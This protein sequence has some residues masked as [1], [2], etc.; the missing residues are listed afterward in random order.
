MFLTQP[1]LGTEVNEHYYLNFLAHVFHGVADELC[2]LFPAEEKRGYQDLAARWREHLDGPGVRETMYHS[3]VWTA[4]TKW[5]KPE[6]KET[7]VS[8]RS[9]HRP[10]SR[11]SP[12]PPYCR[13][14]PVKLGKH[15][16]VS[17]MLSISGQRNQTIPRLSFTLMT[18]TLSA[19]KQRPAKRS[20]TTCLGL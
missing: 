3:I 11:R 10:T 12:S 9:G 8:L 18:L 6:V 19:W 5:V 13:L 15:L 1:T 17:P 20:T 16:S 4:T 7:S 2:R 14:C